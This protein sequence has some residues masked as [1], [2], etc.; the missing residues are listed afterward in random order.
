MTRVSA[1]VLRAARAYT[2]LSQEALA[3]RAGMA[4]RTVFRRE[5][6]GARQDIILE[7]ILAVLREEGVTL[8]FDDHGA[9]RGLQ[10]RQ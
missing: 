5:N 7:K 8:V 9:V 2:D 3:K 4:K 1:A 6:L 10:F